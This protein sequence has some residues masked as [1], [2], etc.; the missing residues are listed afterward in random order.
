MGISVFV[1]V[2]LLKES[3]F[4]IDDKTR[5]N[6]YIYL[7]YVSFLK[8]I[9]FLIEGYFSP[10]SINDVTLPPI[11]IC[12]SAVIST[13]NLIAL[14]SLNLQWKINK[15]F[16]WYIRVFILDSSFKYFHL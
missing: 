11:I 16:E 9:I 4:G 5:K 15:F 7:W 13:I 14:M 10:Y 2:N 6:I 12:L 8:F 1:G 3:F